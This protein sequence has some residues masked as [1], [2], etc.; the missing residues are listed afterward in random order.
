[1]EGNAKGHARQK[2]AL[3]MQR[4]TMLRVAA[5][6]SPAMQQTSYGPRAIKIDGYTK[7]HARNVIAHSG[8]TLV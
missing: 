2:K 6:K 8:Q 4:T 5:R 3:R 7:G 1:M